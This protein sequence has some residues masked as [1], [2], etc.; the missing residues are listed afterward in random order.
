MAP[1]GQGGFPLRPWVGRASRAEGHPGASLPPPWACSSLD[2]PGRW[3][4]SAR[5]LQK[6][7]GVHSPGSQGSQ[8]PHTAAPGHRS[9]SG[10]A[11][12]PCGEPLPSCAPGT[13]S[14]GVP[15]WKSIR[16]AALA[17][18]WAN[19]LGRRG[20]VRGLRSRSLVGAGGDTAWP[21]M[22]RSGDSFPMSV[23]RAAS[24][25]RKL[26]PAG[27]PGQRLPLSKSGAWGL[28]PH[29]CFLT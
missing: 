5:H 14:P 17:A 23:G 19:G 15:P 10:A 1:L 7:P 26:G 12:L 8:A 18:P 9:G 28:P 4:P 27:F 22:G 2:E 11:A 29:P 16:Q 3:V 25:S 24:S 6:C 20:A 13:S 21:E